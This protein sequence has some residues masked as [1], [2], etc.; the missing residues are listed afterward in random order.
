VIVLNEARMVFRSADVCKTENVG[1]LPEYRSEI[2]EE[3]AWEKIAGSKSSDTSARAPEDELA[4]REGIE[5][6]EQ[7]LR[8][9]LDSYAQFAVIRQLF[10]EGLGVKQV[11]EG[12][13]TTTSNVYTLKSRALARLRQNEQI[14]RVLTEFLE[15]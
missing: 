7:M 14:R 8:A 6:I 1:D 12:L 11:A 15:S 13:E 4:E 10:I 3:Y 5:H 2:D 9:A